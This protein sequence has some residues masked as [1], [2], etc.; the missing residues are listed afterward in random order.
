[1]SK[2]LCVENQGEV[3]IRSFYVMG[4]STKDYDKTKIGQFGTGNKYGI[5]ALLRDGHDVIVYSGKK[6]ITFGTKKVSFREKAFNQVIVKVGKSTKE[7]GMAVEMGKIHWTTPKALRELISNAIDEGGFKIYETDEVIG[8]EG[9]TRVYISFSPEIEKYMKM[10]DMEF[11]LNRDCDIVYQGERFGVYEK[12]CDGVIGYRR[13]VQVYFDAKRKAVFDYDFKDIDVGED[14]VS[15]RWDF[16]RALRK[17]IVNMPVA[18]KKRILDAVI[19]MDAKFYIESELE[20]SYEHC[21][22]DWEEILQDTIVIDTNTAAML[23]K[24]LA[25]YKYII[26]PYNWFEYFKKNSAIRTIESVLKQSALR[27]WEQVET[28]PYAEAIIDDVIQFL[29]DVG[30]VISRDQ[31]VIANNNNQNAPFGQYVDGKYYINQSSIRRGFDD[32]L[33]TI[34]HEMFHALS[35]ADDETLEFEDFII[36]EALYHMKRLRVL[37]KK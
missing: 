2:Y 34:V 10:F 7:T 12:Q 21:G 20:M 4:I 29:K 23:Q 28:D 37:L 9:I 26:V 15:S 36:K 27:G 5:T 32:V 3:D 1:M 25:G 8:E 16:C 14:R 24:K 11:T 6:K 22:A 31:I 17:A 18:L 35:E 13:G 33:D 30:Y 19:G